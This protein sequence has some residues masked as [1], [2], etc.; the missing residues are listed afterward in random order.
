MSE[1]ESRKENNRGDSV[2]WRFFPGRGIDI[3]RLL[4][5]LISAVLIPFLTGNGVNQTG[6]F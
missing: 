2:M 5:F 4:I 1:S 6:G 3:S